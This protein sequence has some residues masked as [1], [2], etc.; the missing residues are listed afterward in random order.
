MGHKFGTGRKKDC[1]NKTDVEVY[2]EAILEI[3]GRAKG[4]SDSRTCDTIVS[5]LEAHQNQ[6]EARTRRGQEA[7]RVE[8]THGN[9]HLGSYIKDWGLDDPK[10]QKAMVAMWDGAEN[11]KKRGK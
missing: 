10:V 8:F 2:T 5:K 1:R 6:A 3:V 9:G 4:W 11:R 7:V